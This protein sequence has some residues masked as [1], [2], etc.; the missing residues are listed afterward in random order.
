MPWARPFASLMCACDRVR[1][2]RAQTS[3]PQRASLDASDCAYLLADAI[4]GF[5]TADMSSTRQPRAGGWVK[6]S[7]GD[8][9]SDLIA[10]ADAWMRAQRIRNPER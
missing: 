3:K 8:K 1:D 6:C 7:G 2:Q 4:Q 9:G 10:E 5:E